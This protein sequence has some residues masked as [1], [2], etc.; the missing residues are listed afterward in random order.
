MDVIFESLA[1]EFWNYTKER[2]PVP[3]ER[4]WNWL[5]FNRLFEPHYEVDETFKKLTNLEIKTNFKIPWVDM[6]FNYR[7]YYWI[8]T[9]VD[10]KLGFDEKISI[11]KDVQVILIKDKWWFQE[12][13]KLIDRLVEKFK[14]PQIKKLSNSIFVDVSRIEQLKKINN[15]DFDL[16]KLIWICEE[17]NSTYNSNA[18]LSVSY[19]IRTLIDH[20]PPIFKQTNFEWVLNCYWERSSIKKQFKHLDEWAR[21]RAD[22]N[23]HSQIQRKEFLPTESQIHFMSNIDT[24][25]GEIIKKLS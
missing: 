15:P 16:T 13:N 17:L 2:Q 6:L 22:I 21:P 9:I 23:L 5:I 20:V 1:T 24:L 7:T 18:Y 8:L 25:L 10:S 11:I 14:S 19:L 12:I 3:I 4:L